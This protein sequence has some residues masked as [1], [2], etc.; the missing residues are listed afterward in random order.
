MKPI[1]LAKIISIFFFITN[2]TTVSAQLGCATHWKFGQGKSID[3]SSGIAV[4]DTNS[5]MYVLEGCVSY[6]DS[7][8]QLLFYSNGV[9]APFGTVWDKNHQAMPNG[10]LTGFTGVATPG[11]S[12]IVIPMPGSGHEYYLFTIDGVENYNTNYKGL[13]Y[14][15]I[16]MSLNNGLGDVTLKGVQ[17]NVPTTQYLHES[18]TATRN[19][20]GT[21]YWLI[22][23][24]VALFVDSIHQT[25]DFWVYEVTN[26][27]IS[28]P[29]QQSIGS[30]LTHHYS[31]GS[32]KITVQGDRLVF[33]TEIFDFDNSTG[34]ISNP[35]S[36]PHNGYHAFSKCGRF[37]YI[38]NY[39]AGLYQIDLQ[40]SNLS[41]Y[42]ILPAATY[43]DWYADLQI[44]PDGKVYL[45]YPVLQKLGIINAPDQLGALCN[46]TSNLPTPPILPN[47]AFSFSLPNYADC[48]IFP[49][50]DLLS[51]NEIT[52]CDSFASPGGDGYY[53]SDGIYTDTI[54]STC[55]CEDSIVTTELTI[56]TTD[57][58]VTT[59]S[60][61]ELFAVNSDSGTSYQWIDCFDNNILT[62]ENSQTFTATSNGSYAV[63][64]ESNG[65]TDTSEC[66]Q[67]TD[68]NTTEFSK[69]Q[70]DIYPNPA[71]NLLILQPQLNLP[72]R[73]V[74]YNALGEMILG[75]DQP[76]QGKHTIVLD[77]VNN[78]IY[79]L[80]VFFE[81]QV[82]SQ[83]VQIIK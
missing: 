12:S 78:G 54:P 50:G 2:Y 28:A 19:A 60:P 61:V 7:A 62:G 10:D 9:G 58:Q 38:S 21:G 69:Y 79:V 13:C 37:L 47:P 57:A 52:A 25:N 4:P 1:S 51:Y 55:N 80:Q 49:C 74:L 34:L 29:S 72:Y 36:L 20:S 82:Y 8:G 45:I 77:D 81:N 5:N 22:V 18:I 41:S 24:Q 33:A 66:V 15:I 48:D 16:D 46:F 67:I 32:M 59:L 40:S 65:C 43:P 14:S 23:H 3:F 31:Y 64:I 39:M 26:A 17:M 44:G 70:I 42:Q 27:G 83:Q 73:Y 53:T 75:S 68:L 56:V 35:V 6:S 71:T 11:Q 76:C 63:I 30:P